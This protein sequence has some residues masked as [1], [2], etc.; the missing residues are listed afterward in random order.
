VSDAFDPALHL[1]PWCSY[2]KA[3]LCARCEKLV[4]SG[5]NR[6]PLP[7]F[8]WERVPRERCSLCQRRAPKEAA[9]FFACTRHIEE[10]EKR[11]PHVPLAFD[12]PQRPHVIGESGADRGHYF[13]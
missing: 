5:E 7:A 1:C 10:Y 13:F 8:A 4:A 12:K 3:P 6:G 9:A 2:T 11:R